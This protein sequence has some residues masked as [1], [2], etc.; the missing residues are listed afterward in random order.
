MQGKTH[1]L[2]GQKI[3]EQK[4]AI[5]TY[6]FKTG[7]VKAKGKYVNGIMDGKWIFNR[8]SGDLWQ[9]GH[10]KKGVKNGSWVR[11]N[12]VCALEHEALYKDGKL[13][14]PETKSAFP[15]TSKPAERALANARITKLEQLA[16]YTESQILKLHGMGPK[17]VD[18][19]KKAL[20]EKGLAFRNNRE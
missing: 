5:L 12:K 3:Y 4:G 7:I 6:F 11:Y 19:L 1:Y 17:A 8:E 15:K 16:K 18:I 2:N 13:V 20:K 14:K 10:F 9:V